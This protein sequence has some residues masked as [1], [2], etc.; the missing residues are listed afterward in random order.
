MFFVFT[1]ARRMKLKGKAA[2]HGGTTPNLHPTLI[3]FH[4][5]SRPRLPHNMTDTQYSIRPAGFEDAQAIFDLI[6]RYPEELL[7][8]ALGDIV[9]NIDRFLVSEHD[10]TVVGTVSWKILPEI[11]APSNPSIEIQS[12]A[13]APD[14]RGRGAGKKLVTAAVARIR[15]THPAQVIVLTFHT[16]FF[17]RIGFT[18]IRKET[19][20]HKIYAGCINC[21]KYNSPFTCPEIAM[22]LDKDRLADHA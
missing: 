22:V 3:L 10:N 9:Q 5:D 19:L 2:A 13:V 18:V 15:T 11:G 8:R 7:P 17:E 21:V 16:E 20:I 14:H 12:L 4:A 1:I 6:K